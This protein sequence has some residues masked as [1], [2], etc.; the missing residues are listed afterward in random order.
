[1]SVVSIREQ[2][3]FQGDPD[4]GASST[5]PFFG[6]VPTSLSPASPTYIVIERCS[7][8]PEVLCLVKTFLPLEVWRELGSLSTLVLIYRA[9]K[10]LPKNLENHS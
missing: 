2:G 10:G 6:S 8:T 9:I 3:Y 4:Q 5:N 7:K 1:M